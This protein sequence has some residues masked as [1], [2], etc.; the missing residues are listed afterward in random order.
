MAVLIAVLVAADA[1]PPGVVALVVFA[2]GS[3]NALG[4]PAYQAIIPELV[5]PED[6]VAAVGLGSAQWNLGRIVGPALAGLTI[7]LG[8]VATALAVNAVSFLAVIVVLLMIA[9]PRP[10]HHSVGSSVTRAILDALAF[11]RREPVL[12]VSMLSLCVVTFLAAPFIALLP[13]MAVKVLDGDD[14]TTSVLVTAQGVG[15]VAAAFSLGWLAARFGIGRVLVGAVTGLPVVLIGY[16]LAPSLV[17]MA[18]VLVAVGAFYVT[19]LSSVSTIAQLRSPDSL[20]GRVLSLNMM[21]LGL[22]YPV[23]ALVQGRVADVVGLRAT[24]AASALLLLVAVVAVRLLWPRLVAPLA[25]ADRPPP[26][27]VE[28]AEARS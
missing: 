11:V 9:I 18:L 6:L 7:A 19:Q 25:G 17:A 20:R 15:A 2:A 1:A 27:P 21:V 26:S 22:L 4:F 16:A 14:V 28:V 23:G 24:T 13:A 5:P 3:A 12:R 10:K 8:G